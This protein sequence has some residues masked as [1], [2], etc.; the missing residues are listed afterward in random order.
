[1]NDSTGQNDS[2]PGGSKLS[3]QPHYPVMQKR[4]L[5]A[6]AVERVVPAKSRFLGF[7]WV[8]AIGA[9]LLLLQGI[10][11]E[12]TQ[13][14]GIAESQLRS[15]SFQH[16]VE[17]VDI[18]VVEGEQVDFDTR[19]LE[20]RRYDLYIELQVIDEQ[21]GE[22]RARQA[23]TRHLAN[24][25]IAN[26]KAELS[27]R[28]QA[29]ATQIDSLES[30]HRLN[31]KLLASI[32]S[33]AMPGSAESSP[34][35]VRIDGLK[36]EQKRLG[37][38]YRTRIEQQQQ[39]LL[40]LSGPGDARIAELGKNKSELRRQ[41]QALVVRAPF[42][43]SIGS[44]LFKQGEQVAAF[45]PVIS[46]QGSHPGSVKG[47]IHEA[48]SNHVQIGQSVWV[49][50]L[51]AIGDDPLV[52]GRVDSLGS[53]IVEYPERLKRNPL[54]SAWGR[55]A[56][57]S[58][59]PGSGI[60]QGEKVAVVLQRPVPPQQRLARLLDEY[61]PIAEV[62][63][64]VGETAHTATSV[65]AAIDVRIELSDPRE[66]E[67]SGLVWYPPGEVYLLVSDEHSAIFEL[68]PDGVL[69]A[70][71]DLDED[72]GV[73]DL[74]S[75]SLDGGYLYLAASTS[76]NR[77]GEWRSERGKFLRIKLQQG[78]IASS[79]SIDLARLLAELANNPQTEA[80]ARA[81]LKT[82]FKSGAIDV[83][84][85]AVRDNRLYLGFKAPQDDDASSVI[86]QLDDVD[87]LFAG[88]PPKASTW[89]SIDLGKA[90]NGKRRRLSDI[91]ID[92]GDIYLLSVAAAGK[93]SISFLSHY[94]LGNGALTHISE[95]P[96]L[97]AEGISLDP[98]AKTATIVFDG[99]GK[100]PSRWIRSSL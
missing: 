97:K 68:S 96:G 84:S 66:I 16:P 80:R 88:R 8:L 93:K 29:L 48:V 51:N 71:I 99:G 14:Y 13:F 65:A 20:V 54:V 18:P 90:A 79:E 75:V 43:G 95:Y 28:Q 26:L 58:I 31:Q 82:A 32:S 17:I 27:A 53:R 72:G 2:L 85:H 73:D 34:M 87:G 49:Q 46:I 63:A 81:F 6:R 52:R 40:D 9:T 62:Q 67:A 78:A 25:E 47:Y 69:R 86:L 98:D 57:I 59:A 91:A 44:V 50:S 89:L 61:L 56:I 74:E 10:Q 37:Q 12:A 41:A 23:S 45:S 39:I 64:W 4:S 3:V 21:I 94:N 55:E 100:E 77:K 33:E 22:I 36:A 7:V 19:I 76:K 42:A 30:T 24:A 15:I 1:V 11:G 5:L 35:R 60:L 92:G 70:R 83:E 38:L